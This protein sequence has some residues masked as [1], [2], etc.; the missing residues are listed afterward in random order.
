MVGWRNDRTSKADDIQLVIESLTPII[1]ILAALGAGLAAW[2]KG[3]DASDPLLRFCEL[4]TSGAIGMIVPRGHRYQ[5][6]PAG[7]AQ[8][9]PARPPVPPIRPLPTS[10]LQPVD[11]PERPYGNG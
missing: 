8:R 11:D 2:W 10:R 7:M 3:A 9:P 6:P 4:V 5:Q 1:I